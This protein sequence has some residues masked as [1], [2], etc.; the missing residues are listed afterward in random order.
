MGCLAVG[1]GSRLHQADRH[2]RGGQRG[3]LYAGRRS[4]GGVGRHVNFG[5][6]PRR[7]PGPRQDI[8]RGL[9]FANVT[10]VNTTNYAGA[11]GTTAYL[12]RDGVRHPHRSTG[13]LAAVDAAAYSVA[14]SA[15]SIT[16]TVTRTGSTRGAVT[17]NYAAG[18]GTAPAGLDYKAT[19]GTLAFADGVATQTFAIPIL[20]DKLSGNQTVNLTLTNPTN[21]AALGPQGAATLTIVNNDAPY[22]PGPFLD[23]DGDKYTVTL[24]GPGTA[25]IMLNDPDG[26]GHG[27]INSILLQGTTAATTL[28]VTVT[29]AAGGDGKVSIG[30]IVSVA[31]S[32]GDGSL[33]AILAGQSDVIGTGV[34]LAGTVG[35][36]TLGNLANGAD[37][38][39]GG[40]RTATAKITLGSVPG[41]SAIQSTSTL[42]SLTAVSILGGS[43]TAPAIGTLSVTVGSLLA[44]LSVAGAVT[45]IS[46]KG[47]GQGTWSAASFGTISLGGGFSGSL[48]STATVASLGKTAALSKLTTGGDFQGTLHA[49]WNPFYN[50]RRR[51]NVEH[52]CGRSLDRHAGRGPQSGPVHDP[53][54]RE[55]RRRLPDRRPRR[56]CGFLWARLD[57]QVLRGRKCQRLHGRRGARS[58]RFRLPQ[59]Q[60]YD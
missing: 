24:S 44:D 5:A 20:D 58:K 13:R 31:G 15:G 32:T 57:Q 36:L 42:G 52:H 3:V 17:V 4:G 53:S 6:D 55:P 14:E 33:K 46:V 35:Q 21:G 39:V 28:T 54:R 60:R 23:S 47:G 37:I 30:R 2:G 45:S 16:V 10:N 8:R 38:T 27:S 9:I 22:G 11:A 50:Q 1:H 18:G 41:V 43:I 56:Q 26:D 40:T 19:S 59:R 29:K 34:T 25:G 51:L 12:A 48:I 7:S 49:S